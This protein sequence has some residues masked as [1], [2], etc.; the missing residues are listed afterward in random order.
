MSD[1]LAH[2]NF[3][4]ILWKECK[5]EKRNI[6]RNILQMKC[7]YDFLMYTGG[8]FFGDYYLSNWIFW[9]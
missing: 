3:L 2:D 9:M 7:I 8:G 4:T 6:F 1:P 5:G